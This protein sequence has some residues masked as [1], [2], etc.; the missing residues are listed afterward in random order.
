MPNTILSARVRV[1]IVGAANFTVWRRYFMLATAFFAVMSVLVQCES[2]VART[3]VRSGCI[4][5]LVLATAVVDRTLV[6]ICADNNNSS[7]RIRIFTRKTHI[8]LTSKENCGKSGFM[9]GT[10]RLE[11]HTKCICL[12][13]DHGRRFLATIN[14]ML[15]QFIR[16][17]FAINFHTVIL[18][19]GL[20]VV[21]LQFIIKSKNK[22][23]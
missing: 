6:H 1:W 18:A 19:F 8:L 3:L 5:A 17:D 11:L 14:S 2:I 20:N 4:F 21:H 15:S 13:R 10:V 12:R 7:K 9:Y 22:M 16:S 23:P